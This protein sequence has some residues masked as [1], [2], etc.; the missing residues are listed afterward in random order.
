MSR[1]GRNPKRFWRP[2][3]GIVVAYAVA[4]QSLLI[5]LGGF[6]LAAPANDVSPA[7]ELCLHEGA[8]AP[9][10]PAGAPT[11]AP[12]THCVFCFA[13]ANAAVIGSPPALVHRAHFEVV[14][15]SGTLG[16]YRPPRVAQHLIPSPRGPPPRV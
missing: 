2:L 4:V 7:F 6:A 10:L 1:F 11:H 15:I 14:D 9:A 8:A 5:A 12:C 13:G 16:D 3:I